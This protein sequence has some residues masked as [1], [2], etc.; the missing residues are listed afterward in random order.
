MKVSLAFSGHK[1]L[2][3]PPGTGVLYVS[4]RVD[5]DSLREGGAVLD[6]V[7]DI[8]VRTGLHCAPV[9][10]K[11]LG[12]YPLG[13][14]RL[15]PGYFN[16]LEEVE[17][18]LQAIDRIARTTPPKVKNLQMSQKKGGRLKVLKSRNVS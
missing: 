13:T 14:I 1:G 17:L 3:G 6:S 8:K 9:A 7:F 16:T 12:T 10:H 11:T 18:T 2:L 4:K 15:S 5:L